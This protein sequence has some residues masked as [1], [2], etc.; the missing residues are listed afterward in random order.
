MIFKYCLQILLILTDQKLAERS[1]EPFSP[2]ESSFSG[3]EKFTG[4][5]NK[6]SKIK[7]SPMSKHN[8]VNSLKTQ[9]HNYI[10]YLEENQSKQTNKIE[11]VGTYI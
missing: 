2:S 10:S 11:R 7:L 8:N 9:Q 3:F 6:E 4:I 1:A 5:L